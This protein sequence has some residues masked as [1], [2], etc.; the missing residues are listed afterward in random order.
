MTQ[1]QQ[2][3]LLDSILPEIVKTNDPEGAMLKCARKHNLAPA[4]LEKLAQV[5][6]TT[7]TIVGLTKQANRGDSFSIVNVPELVSK[8]TTYDPAAELS[9]ESKGVHAKVNR[10]VKSASAGGSWNP[11][12]ES[13][14]EERLPNAFLTEFEKGDWD[15]HKA[16]TPG[17]DVVFGKRASALTDDLQNHRDSLVYRFVNDNLDLAVD[18]AYQVAYDTHMDIQEKCAS[19]MHKLTPDEGRWAVC[20]QDIVDNLGLEKAASVIK[21]VED[22]FIGHRHHFK[23]ADLTKEASGWGEVFA[24]DHHG[25]VGIAEEIY[26]LQQINKEAK[27]AYARFA[28]AAGKGDKDDDSVI[29]ADAREGANSVNALINGM[30]HPFIPGPKESFLAPVLNPASNPVLNVANALASTK[31]S[32]VDPAERKYIDKSRDLAMSESALQDLM[33]SDKT[34]AEA[35]PA[36]VRALYETVSRLSPTIA[37][38]P[39]VLAPVLKEALQY[40]SLPIQQVKDL[41]DAEKT[42]LQNKVQLTKL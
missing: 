22:Y 17:Y 24:K 13:V 31:G 4:Q 5:F 32:L 42:S 18:K 10:L 39:V 30:S 19:I 21:S 3:Q 25:V 23:P 9:R 40:G 35:D 12:D 20:V 14:Q 28:K 37:Q 1:K 15:E 2:I 33:M 34:I 29:E 6:N 38:D 11:F 36:E 7:K 41:L 16:H 26:D 8:Y 27:A